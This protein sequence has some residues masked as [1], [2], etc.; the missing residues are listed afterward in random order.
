MDGTVTEYDRQ[1]QNAVLEQWVALR[2]TATRKEMTGDRIMLAEHFRRTLETQCLIEGARTTSIQD[3]IHLEETTRQGPEMQD[4]NH[5]IPALHHVRHVNSLMGIQTP[6]PNTLPASHSIASSPGIS[7]GTST[8]KNTLRLVV[9]SDT[10]GY[11]ESLT[12]N[13]TPL[14]EG[15]ILLHLGDFA[16]D[17][18]VRK[19]REAL[20]KFDEWLSVQN[21]RIK[22]VLR[23]NHDPFSVDFSKVSA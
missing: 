16:I 13:G 8:L 17:G 21:H 12:P 18:S 2:K 5:D 4:S 23:G 1:F 9:I 3:I 10:H 20:R 22:L 7:D 6:T 11:E 14:P 15:D 19:K